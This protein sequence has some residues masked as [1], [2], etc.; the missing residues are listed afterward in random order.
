MNRTEIVNEEII[1]SLNE[2]ND[3]DHNDLD[4]SDIGNEI[5]A[6]IAKYFNEDEIGFDKEA[7]IA[8]LNHGISITDGTH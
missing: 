3:L 5:G 2:M 8:G 7:F 1:N 4:L 6:V